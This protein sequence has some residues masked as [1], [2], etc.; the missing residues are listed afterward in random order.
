MSNFVDFDEI[1]DEELEF[2]FPEESEEEGLKP[3]P[4][5][6]VAGMTMAPYPL[7]EGME[8]VADAG[9]LF[10]FTGSDLTPQQQMYII[11]FATRGTKT[12]AAKAAGVPYSVV[13]KWNEDPEFR[14][15]L[16]EALEMVT[17]TLEEELFR[18]AMT[19]SDT[20]M[21][22][23]MKAYKPER[24]ARKE[25]KDINV[26]GNVVHT[27]ADLASE[28]AKTLKAPAVNVIDADFEEVADG[29]DD[30]RDT[31][32][33]PGDTPDNGNPG[34][35]IDETGGGPESLLFLG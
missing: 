3:L 16:N 8:L 19:G 30:S 17:D 7:R 18:R 12:A 35:S 29:Q 21:K 23:A 31:S 15:C 32:G 24:Y 14:A 22:E 27:W 25:T 28:A 1:L 2:G 4:V 6:G 26:S 13:Q 20:L 9:K 11:Q 10:D 33:I 34:G 5:Q